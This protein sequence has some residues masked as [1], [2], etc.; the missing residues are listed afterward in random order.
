[1]PWFP[2][3]SKALERFWACGK[4]PA[5]KGENLLDVF[6]FDKVVELTLHG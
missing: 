5:T 2:G 1:M 3:I 6:Y 4:V